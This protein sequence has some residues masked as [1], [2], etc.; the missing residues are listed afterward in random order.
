MILVNLMTMKMMIF[1]TNYDNSNNTYFEINKKPEM[2]K[3]P[4]IIDETAE[5][6]KIV[7]EA[8]Y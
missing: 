6:Q 5:P 2:R 8:P 3:A 1:Y 4:S 7:Y